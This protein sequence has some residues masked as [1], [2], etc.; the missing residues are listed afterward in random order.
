MKPEELINRPRY[1]HMH[2][3]WAPPS[4]ITQQADVRLAW[5]RR[6]DRLQYQQCVCLELPLSLLQ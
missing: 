5:E 2:L 3:G 1:M 6:M 4:T